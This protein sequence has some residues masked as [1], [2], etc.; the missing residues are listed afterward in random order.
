[1]NVNF[2]KT[3]I[4]FFFGNTIIDFIF[5]WIKNT[6]KPKKEKYTIRNIHST[7]K[8]DYWRKFFSTST[9]KIIPIGV[10]LDNS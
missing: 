2:N 8:F 10:R 9:N 3:S 6:T 7:T 4:P 5:F 1:M